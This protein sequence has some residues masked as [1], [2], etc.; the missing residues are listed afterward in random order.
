M[1]QHEVNVVEYACAEFLCFP[2]ENRQ[3]QSKV[4]RE[5]ARCNK[6][7]VDKKL[8]FSEFLRA[9]SGNWSYAYLIAVLFDSIHLS[10]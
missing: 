8:S 4:V 1:M 7:P 5:E 10:Y 9:N 6:T 3:L 2:S